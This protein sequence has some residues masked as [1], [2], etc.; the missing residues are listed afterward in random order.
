MKRFG[1]WQEAGF[2][3]AKKPRRVDVMGALRAG[4][5]K[6]VDVTLSTLHGIGSADIVQRFWVCL[7]VRHPPSTCA[8]D[9]CPIDPSVA[10]Q[11][12]CFPLF[13]SLCASGGDSARGEWGVLWW[14]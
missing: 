8:T 3:E 2:E 11:T 7:Q 13:V 6:L 10:Q 14:G 4:L 5:D 9:L 1:T 12:C